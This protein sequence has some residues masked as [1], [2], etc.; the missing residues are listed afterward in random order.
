[1]GYV[2]VVPQWIKFLSMKPI[3]FNISSEFKE[4]DFQKYWNVL[5]QMDQGT[6]EHYEEAPGLM[7]SERANK[8][9]MMMIMMMMM[10]DDDGDGDGIGDD[11]LLYMINAL[12][13]F[14]DFCL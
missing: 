4:T 7:K 9:S 14:S 10:I 13:I 12:I 11:T 5:Y 6:K 3:V 1:M 2:I 8:W